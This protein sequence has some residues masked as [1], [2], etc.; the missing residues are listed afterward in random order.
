MPLLPREH[1]GRDGQVNQEVGPCQTPALLAP[2][3]WTSQ[4]LELWEIN[5]CCL[6]A[7]QSM[8]VGYNSLND[9]D[10]GQRLYRQINI[11]TNKNVDSS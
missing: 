7:T 9:G 11:K 5:F 1:T 3:S 10:T 6:S 4:A 8:V 2:W